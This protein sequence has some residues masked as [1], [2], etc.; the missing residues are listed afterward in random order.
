M[1]L[2]YQFGGMYIY[3]TEYILILY[4]SQPLSDMHSR[5]RSTLLISTYEQSDGENDPLELTFRNPD[6]NN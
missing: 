6:A 5:I 1:C 4:T 3:L 2:S